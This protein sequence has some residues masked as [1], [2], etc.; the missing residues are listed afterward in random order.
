VRCSSLVDWPVY[1]RLRGTMQAST[2][3][4]NKPCGRGGH[5]FPPA[6]AAR[7]T[8]RLGNEGIFF[9]F[10]TIK[11]ANECATATSKLARGCPRE[12]NCRW[13]GQPCASLSL[14]CL[15]RDGAAR[16]NRRAV[17]LEAWHVSEGRQATHDG[18]GSPSAA[19]SSE[20]APCLSLWLRSG[21]HATHCTPRLPTGS[22]TRGFGTSL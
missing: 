19:A 6:C 15:V 14:S 17:P 16:P 20:A 11:A 7:H 13:I 21:D 8:G 12:T 1:P 2:R 4:R 22:G 5:K 18:Q 3:S 9:F 10:E